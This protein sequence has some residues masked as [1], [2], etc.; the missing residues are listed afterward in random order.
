MN[1]DLNISFYK[2]AF[3][4]IVQILLL[5]FFCK[6]TH[7]LVYIKKIHLINELISRVKNFLS[8][9]YSF[10]KYQEVAHSVHFLRQNFL[11]NKLS[12]L[13]DRMD[14]EEKRNFLNYKKMLLNSEKQ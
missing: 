14:F 2:F 1:I 6:C 5:P 8:D 9:T 4:Q 3:L 11:G 13:I 10:L 12:A 7:K